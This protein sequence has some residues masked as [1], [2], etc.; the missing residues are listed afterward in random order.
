MFEVKMSNESCKQQFAFK[1]ANEFLNKNEL[2]FLCVGSSR[3]VADCLGPLV[4]EL[5]KHKYKINHPVYGCLEN[6]VNKNNLALYASFIKETYPNHRVVVVDC[7]LGKLEEMGSLRFKK[8]GCIP[9]GGLSNTTTILGDYSMLGILNMVGINSLLFLK[10]Y[11]LKE[12]MESA[13]F[14]AEGIF[15]GTQLIKK[16]KVENAC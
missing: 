5:L 15:N 12:I 2:V 1:F 13:N 16:I 4:G 11:K 9:G 6:N 8:G 10:S 7:A 14:I 3:V